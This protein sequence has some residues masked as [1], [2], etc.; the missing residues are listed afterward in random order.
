MYWSSFL[1]LVLFGALG[2]WIG[3][4]LSHRLKRRKKPRKDE[5]SS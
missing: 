2:A 4:F 3:M 1:L 5:E